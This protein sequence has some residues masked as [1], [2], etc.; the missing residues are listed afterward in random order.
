MGKLKEETRDD[1]VEYT[2]H[3][4]PLVCK[5]LTTDWKKPGLMVGL[6]CSL[7]PPDETQT[8]SDI[9]NR[10]NGTSDEEILEAT[11]IHADEN[12]KANKLLDGSDLVKGPDA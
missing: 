4:G 9:K 7:C 11:M 10:S 6:V 3:P 2:R 8:L 12:M 1:I 5:D